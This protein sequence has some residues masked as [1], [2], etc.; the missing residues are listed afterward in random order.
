MTT[1]VSR[2]RGST[3]ARACTSL[4]KSEEKERLLAVYKIGDRELSFTFLESFSQGGHL[5]NLVYPEL[6]VFEESKGH[7]FI[8]NK[9]NRNCVLAHRNKAE[10]FLVVHLYDRTKILRTLS[11]T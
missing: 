11:I 4:T 1:R 6:I 3:L 7:L 5:P 2:L 10:L 8:D 9:L